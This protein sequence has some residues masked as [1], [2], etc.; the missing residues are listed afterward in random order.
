MRNT[1]GLNKCSNPL[2]QIHT[3]VAVAPLVVIPGDKL[4]EGITQTIPEPA[5]KMEDA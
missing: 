5:S 2:E 1:L 3:T 4:K